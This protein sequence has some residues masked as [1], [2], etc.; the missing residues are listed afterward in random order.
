MSDEKTILLYALSTL[1]QTCAALAAFV[2]VMALHRL[3]SLRARRGAVLHDIS[4]ALGHPTM[5]MDQLLA[6]A[7]TRA[8]DDHPR[9]ATLLHD[10]DGALRQIKRSSQALAAFE[11]W[12][13]LVIFAALVG[14][15]HVVRLAACPLALHALWPVALVTAVVTGYC[16]FVWTKE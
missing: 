14:F 1:A 9:L 15:D 12:N 13:L 7:R 4:A 11:A 8:K 3:Q 5:T 10:L 16:V 6:G 2:G